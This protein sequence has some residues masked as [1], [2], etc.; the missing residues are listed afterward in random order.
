MANR[1]KKKK[2]KTRLYTVPQMN[3]PDCIQSRAA[4]TAILK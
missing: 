4:L 3:Q 1:K 2:T